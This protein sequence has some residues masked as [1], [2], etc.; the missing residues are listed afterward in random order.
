MSKKIKIIIAA[1]GTG[2]HVFPGINLAKH[3]I[4][5]SFFE[6]NLITDKRGQKIFK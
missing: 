3:L 6:V 4:N 1:G 5:K 2:G